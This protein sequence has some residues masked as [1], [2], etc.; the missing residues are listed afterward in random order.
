MAEPHWHIVMM[1]QCGSAT[2]WFSRYRWHRD[3]VASWLCH[4]A[5][6]LHCC[7]VA[8]LHCDSVTYQEVFDLRRSLVL[9]LTT[10]FR[11]TWT[12]VEPA[13]C[14]YCPNQPAGPGGRTSSKWR[15][16]AGEGGRA[17]QATPMTVAMTSSWRPQFLKWGLRSGLAPRL[18]GGVIDIQAAAGLE[19]PD[20]ALPHCHTATLL[21]RDSVTCREAFNPRRSLVP[22][23]TTFRSTW[24]SLSQPCAGRR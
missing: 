20:I 5:T 14:L 6:L 7:T 15:P 18:A 13:M 22:R 9:W 24:T 2:W 16:L 10:P 3:D 8:L 21:H 23:L 12:F 19:R 11:S 4:T 1:L 17:R